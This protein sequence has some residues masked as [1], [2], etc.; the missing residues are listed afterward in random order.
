MEFC[1]IDDPVG[2]IGVH[3]GAGVWA[4]IATGLFAE[5]GDPT[6]NRMNGVFR[7][8]S[9]E[10]LGWNMLAILVVTLWSGGLAAITVM[11]LFLIKS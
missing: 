5:K 7:K 2:C 10:L 9:G 8:G 4:M 11:F 1:K 3:W 6:S